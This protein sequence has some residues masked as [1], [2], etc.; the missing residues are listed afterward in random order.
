MSILRLSSLAY[1]F[2]LNIK[3]TI[4]RCEG[5]ILGVAELVQSALSSGSN[6]SMCRPARSDLREEHLRETL[7]RTG[8]N[9]SAAARL[10]GSKRSTLFDRL[11]RLGLREVV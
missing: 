9:I 8:G 6:S 10:L 11:T 4:L 1:R 2:F 3:R 5:G 7:S